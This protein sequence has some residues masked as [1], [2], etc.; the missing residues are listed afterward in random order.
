MIAYLDPTSTPN[1]HKQDSIAQLNGPRYRPAEHR[2]VQEGETS[3]YDNSN[4]EIQG[5]VYRNPVATTTM[6]QAVYQCTQNEV[7]DKE[8]HKRLEIER[9]KILL[10]AKTYNIEDFNYQIPLTINTIKTRLGLDLDLIKVICCQNCF[11]LSPFPTPEEPSEDN[12]SPTLDYAAQ[13]CS[14]E[15]LGNHGSRLPCNASLWKL[16]KNKSTY[17]P[18]KK[19]VHQ[20]FIRWLGTKLIWPQFEGQLD[21]HLR[22]SNVPQNTYMDIWD[23]K[24][25]K[26]FKGQDNCVFTTKSGNL[27]F[28]LYLDWVNPHGIKGGS[29]SISIGI[30]FLVC[31][32]LPPDQQYKTHNLFIYGFTPTPREPKSTQLKN[33]LGP[34]VEE[35]QELWKG[36]QFTKTFHHPNGQ[37]IRV[38][39]LPLIGDT[40]ALR[41]VAGLADHSSTL[42]CAHCN[43]TK[44]EIRNITKS[45]WPQKDEEAMKKGAS[46]W[47]DAP[48]FSKQKT[49][50]KQNGVKYSVLQ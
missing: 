28:G 26:T 35:L 43:L 38:A 37:T 50:L 24:M 29:K 48:N 8:I 30:I 23:G 18:I 10:N 6:I 32:N 39:I 22:R 46:E 15:I 42:F 21:S 44:E 40:P 17:H 47:F 49:L 45:T 36:V 3:T 14:E 31:F 34:L 11:N 33:L 19:F 27:V 20:S 9:A 1:L 16:N 12:P 4:L 5:F 2:H 13:K 25:W 7:S 41:K